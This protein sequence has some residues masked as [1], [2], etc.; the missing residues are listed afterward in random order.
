ML[1]ATLSINDKRIWNKNL[2]V[3][4]PLS[5]AEDHVIDYLRERGFVPKVLDGIYEQDSDIRL[6]S[7]Q[8][9]ANFFT[10][11]DSNTAVF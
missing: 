7:A 11:S 1:R 2:N 9:L 8:A 4:I 6:K 10:G 3:L 5:N